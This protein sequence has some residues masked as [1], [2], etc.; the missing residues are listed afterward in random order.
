MTLSRLSLT[1]FQKH[2]RLAL[3]LDPRLTSI[4]GDSDRGKSAVLRALAWLCLNSFP[5]R[6]APAT[7]PIPSRRR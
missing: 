4:A 1:N 7:G 2:E 5:T 3:D 6:D